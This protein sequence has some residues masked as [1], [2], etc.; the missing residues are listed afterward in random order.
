[1]GTLTRVWPRYCRV[2]RPLK[3]SRGQR[4]ERGEK[5]RTDH[6]KDKE[7]AKRA[8]LAS[9]KDGSSRREAD[10]SPPATNGQMCRVG[11]DRRP[12]IASWSLT[13]PN[14]GLH[15]RETPTSN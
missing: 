1:M 2:V 6:G 15:G 8:T 4:W 14:G 9:E 10:K 12:R 13:G 3:E 7:R 5:T 11:R